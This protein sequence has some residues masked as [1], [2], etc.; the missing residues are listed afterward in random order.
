MDEHDEEDF[1]GYTINYEKL[2]SDTSMLAVTRLLATDLMNKPY[3]NVGSF[4]KNL[5]DS[6]LRTL[7]DICEQSEEDDTPGSRFQEII[8]ISQMLAEAEGSAYDMSLDGVIMRTRS[9]SAFFAVESLRRKGLVKVHHHNM[10]F[11]ED[12]GDRIVVEK[13]GD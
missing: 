11:G 3:Y 5:S 12:A 2:I 13:I 1:E 10:S 7:S 9:L 6:D 4:I 8:L